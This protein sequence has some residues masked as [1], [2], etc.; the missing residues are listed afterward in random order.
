MVKGEASDFG[1][2][3]SGREFHA[4]TRRARR[5]EEIIDN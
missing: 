4:E 5:R 3:A 2:Q 1:L